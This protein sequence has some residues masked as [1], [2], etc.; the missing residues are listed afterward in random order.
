M[1]AD[2]ETIRA[3]TAPNADARRVETD[4]LGGTNH[5]WV[6]TLGVLTC[7]PYRFVDLFCGCG[8]FTC[9]F[10]AA[11][12]HPVL[13]VEKA[14]FDDPRQVIHAERTYRRNFP[15]V[16]LH[17]RGIETL[18]ARQ[19]ESGLG[20][21][22]PHVVI[23]GPPCTKF[24]VATTPD[25][26]HPIAQLYL[27]YIRILGALRPQVCV[28]ENVPGLLRPKCRPALDDIVA[29]LCD[30]GYDH[31]SVLELN[32]AWYGVPQTRERLI[33]IANRLG[34]PNAYP[35]PLLTEAELVPTRDVLLDLAD[36][37]RD[38][39]WSHDWPVHGERVADELDPLGPGGRPPGKVQGYRRLDPDRPAW[40][41]IDNHGGAATH[42]WLP[43]VVSVREMARLQSFPDSFA[44]RGGVTAERRQVGNAVPPV[45]AKHIARAVAAMLEA[46]GVA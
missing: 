22:S 27:E 37:P 17:D 3:S 13:A 35:E 11:G 4:L 30:L 14:E 18:T 7:S 34:I 5:R 41:V 32:A 26:T 15:G 20:G 42:Q 40:T 46:A 2:I 43:R 16:W 21:G 19:L 39:D 10:V 9:G 33:I 31:V 29:R 38:L 44:F 45:M 1:S 24:S 25:L 12:L 6:D 23:G 28:I 36:H 8:G